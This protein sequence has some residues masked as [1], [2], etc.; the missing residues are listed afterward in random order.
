MHICIYMGTPCSIDTY[1]KKLVQIIIKQMPPTKLSSSAEQIELDLVRNDPT[2]QLAEIFCCGLQ[3]RTFT[4]RLMC[5]CVWYLCIRDILLALASHRAK[6]KRVA[7]WYFVASYS[8]TTPVN[9]VPLCLLQFVA[10]HHAT[11]WRCV[12][13]LRSSRDRLIAT[14]PTD[15]I[16]RF[17]S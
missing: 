16:E 9:K 7:E 15:E 5:S 6:A 3:A 2:N 17:H 1:E 10:K 8:C 12:T 4:R 11:P 13:N 14:V